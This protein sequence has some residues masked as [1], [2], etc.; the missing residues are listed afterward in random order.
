MARTSHGF[1]TQFLNQ[2]P[3]ISGDELFEPKDIRRKRL[4]VKDKTILYLCGESY[5]FQKFSTTFL[6]R[7]IGT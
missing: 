1:V 6:V 4:A 5:D 2:V 7:I 3:G